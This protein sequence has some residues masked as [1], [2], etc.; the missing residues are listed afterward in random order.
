MTNEYFDQEQIIEIIKNMIAS[1]LS[2]CELVFD[3][4][5]DE[6]DIIKDMFENDDIFNY[7]DITPSQYVHYIDLKDTLLELRENGKL[8]DIL[9]EL[10]ALLDSLIQY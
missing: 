3:D 8:G 1:I 4:F 10:E 9:G 6:F 7:Y 2:D 5:K